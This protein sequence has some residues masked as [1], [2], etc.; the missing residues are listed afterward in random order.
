MAGADDRPAGDAGF[1]PPRP[2]EIRAPFDPALRSDAGVVFIGH[3]STP[4]RKGD[5][6]KNLTEA[7]A[8]ARAQTGRFSARVEPEYRPALTGLE[9]GAKVILLYWMAGS[10]RDLLVQAPSHRP[11]PRGTFA[12][13]SPARPNPIAL[14][15]V[16]VLSVDATAGVVEVDAL[17]A[18]DGTPLL[19]IKPWLP[20][21]DIPPDLPEG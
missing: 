13:R 14:A 5:C 2:G 3:L 12:L 18:F 16:T 6:P 19:D 11:D 4:W 15:A 1:D 21:V 10:R 7:R 9:A 17:D 20:G 8:R